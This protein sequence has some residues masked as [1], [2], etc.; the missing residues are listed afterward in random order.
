MALAIGAETTSA[1]SLLTPEFMAKLDALSVISKKILAG[2]LRGERR[3]RKKGES[4]EFADHRSYA[5]GDD[6]RR[7]DWSLYA[8]LERLFVK[9]F[10]A[11]EDLSV[12]LILDGSASMD[13]GSI[14]KFDYARKVAAA[15]AYIGISNMDRVSLGVYNGGEEHLL[16]NIRGKKQVFKLFDFLSKVR[17]SGGTDLH[18]SCKRFLLR[19]RRPGV[20]LVLSD[21]LDPEGYEGPLKALAANRMDAFAV[22]V[23][24]PEEVEPELTGDF[25]LVDSETGERIDVTASRRLVENY[26]KTV[27]GFCSSLQ[28]FCAARGIAYLFA[29]TDLPFEALVLNYLRSVGLVR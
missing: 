12:Y 5:Q 23:L 24:A 19:N 10:Q 22:H 3:S 16:S 4:L 15:L 27:R 2:K 17:P 21:F 14:N 18:A 11:E 28:Q 29:S 25:L 26:R 8:R 13:W 7:I 9:L 1:P 20:C 6:L